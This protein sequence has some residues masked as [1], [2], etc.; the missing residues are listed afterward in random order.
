MNFLTLLTFQSGD[1]YNRKLHYRGEE[2]NKRPYLASKI[3]LHILSN[4]IQYGTY[5]RTGLQVARIHRLPRS[6]V[7]HHHLKKRAARPQ[8]GPLE[9]AKRRSPY[10]CSPRADESPPR[11][12]ST[13][14]SG[15]IRRVKRRDLE[16]DMMSRGRFHMSLTRSL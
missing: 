10:R 4:P 6:W 5:S 3:P 13:R 14:W 12:R 16:H 15:R 9:S 1:I 7:P 2:V 8:L 11:L